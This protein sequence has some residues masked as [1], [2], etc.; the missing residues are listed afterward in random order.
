[1]LTLDCPHCGNAFPSAIQ[2]QRTFEMMRV[3][4]ILERSPPRYRAFRLT[5]PEYRNVPDEAL[6]KIRTHRS[7][8]VN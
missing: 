8:D 6:P 2:D 7:D 1:M 3:E 4:R 5:K